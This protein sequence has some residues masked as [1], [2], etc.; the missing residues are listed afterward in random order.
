MLLK[1]F[2]EFFG[3][4]W[5]NF[6]RWTA[7]PIMS[8]NTGPILH[9]ERFFQQILILNP[10]DF[11]SLEQSVRNSLSCIDSVREGD[12]LLL[13]QIGDRGMTVSG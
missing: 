6:K 9:P 11:L 8:Q 4:Y 12:A 3:T 1:S 13:L 2:R 10:K 7:F 5:G